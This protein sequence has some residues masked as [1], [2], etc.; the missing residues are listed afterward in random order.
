[1]IFL[2]RHR[3]HADIARDILTVEDLVADLATVA[4]RGVG[5]SELRDVVVVGRSSDDS[6]VNDSDDAVVVVFCFLVEGGGI[7]RSVLCLCSGAND[8]IVTK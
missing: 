4:V 6:D 1:M 2:V 7:E 3:L 5:V 8:I